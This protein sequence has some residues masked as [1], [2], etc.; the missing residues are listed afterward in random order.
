V[1]RPRAAPAVRSGAHRVA[2][3]TWALEPKALPPLDVLAVVESLEPIETC[4]AIAPTD[5]S[6]AAL[7]LA[8]EL[9]QAAALVHAKVA[10]AAEAAEAAKASELGPL[11]KRATQL[12]DPGALAEVS[13]LLGLG[14][15][16]AGRNADAELRRAIM[17]AEQAR[18]DR[19]RTRASAL[20]AQATAR[21]GRIGEAV[22]NRDLAAS[23]ASRSA[24]PITVLA[25]EHANVAIAFAQQDLASEIAAL[26]RIEAS[27]VA[28]LGDPAFSLVAARFALGSALQRAH[29]PKATA[30]LDRATATLVQLQDRSPLLVLEEAAFRERTP[31]ARLAIEEQGL[32]IARRDDPARLPLMLT[33][34]GYDYELVGDYER[35]LAA[36]LEALE[37]IGSDPAARAELVENAANM[38]FEVADQTDDKQLRAR[39]LDQ[40]LALLDQLPPAVRDGDG[41]QALRGRALLLQGR[42]LDAVPFLAAALTAAERADP[43]HPF[44]IMVRSFALAQALWEAGG[45]RE[46]DRARGLAT[47]AAAR[48]ADAR[49]YFA[50]D[51][52]AYGAAADRVERQATRLEAWR[53]THR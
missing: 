37:R 20:L 41:A 2:T 51:R 18:D 21:A 36:A 4:R 43:P 44:R 27:L 24:D 40:A 13:Y 1:R 6:T 33:S 12:G 5:R 11:A 25:V 16:T 47:A 32:A 53:R 9:E 52:A 26:T 48:I 3:L 8:G 50:A 19:T 28:R 34:I 31:A 49:A 38:A 39:R 35:S 29:D 14:Q 30:A 17:Y 22:A 7:A 10:E 15:H 45:E 46:R 23:A 42:Y